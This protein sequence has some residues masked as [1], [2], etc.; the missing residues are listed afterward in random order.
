[1][2]YTFRTKH[3]K[4]RRPDSLSFAAQTSNE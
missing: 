3:I 4:A 2:Q 1:M